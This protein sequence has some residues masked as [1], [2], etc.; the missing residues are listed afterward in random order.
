MSL[1]LTNIPNIMRHKHWNNGAALMDRWFAGPMRQY[2]NYQT[3]DTSTIK[4]AWALGFGRANAVYRKLV[5]E[6]IW[7]NAAA[8]P[9]VAAMLK[10]KGLLGNRSRRFGNLTAPVNLQDPDYINQR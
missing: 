7:A 3:P 4:M 8:Q 2:P 9:V 10:Q 6:R 1:T 5:R